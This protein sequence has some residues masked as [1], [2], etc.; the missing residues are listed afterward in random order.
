MFL[1]NEFYLMNKDDRILRFTCD[2]SPLGVSFKEEESYE[3]IRPY[4]Y[5]GIGQWIKTSPVYCRL[6]KNVWLL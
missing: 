3:E 5:D 6:V 2:N 4:G 1:E